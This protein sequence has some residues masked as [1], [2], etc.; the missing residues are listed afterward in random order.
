MA[1]LTRR[2]LLLTGLGTGVVLSGLHEWL[3][4]RALNA[5]QASL[6][7]LFLGSPRYVNAAVDSALSGDQEAKAQ[8]EQ[9][10]SSL[11]LTP[12]N[13]PYDREMSKT[14]IQCSR[15]ATEQYLTGKYDRH[16]D[17]TIRPLPTFSDRLEN[18]R[19]VA[20]IRGPEEVEGT[21]TVDVDQNLI[22]GN[23]SLINDPLIGQVNRVKDLVQRLAGQTVTIQWSFPVYW[24]FVLTGP[25]NHV[26][27]LR[28]T[29]RGYEWMQTVRATQVTTQ[30]VPELDFTGGIHKG[31]ANLYSSLSKP[32]IEATKTLDP[33]LPLFISG[34]S[35]GAPLAA[36]A[37][38]DIAKKLPALKAQLRLYTYASPSLGS[39]DFTEEFTQ[40]VPNSYRISNE[41]DAVPLLPPITIEDWVYV[42][43][44]E[45]WVFTTYL[46]EI[47]SHHYVSTY[48][49][50]IDQELEQKLGS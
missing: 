16:F 47:G 29:Q 30:D 1:K 34:H 6:T 13:Q 17:G 23:T 19:Q 49:E 48:R 35:L 41:A 22:L 11:S 14:L 5:Q 7:D 26:L 9:I 45:N 24:G 38:L 20:A 50:A 28:G 4:R 42:P 46:G 40:L 37:A 44:G 10:L 15:L 31:F 27:V 43:L 33:S 21:D 36:L 39:P 3:Q 8:V 2:Q 12:P 18:Y 32:I 25:R